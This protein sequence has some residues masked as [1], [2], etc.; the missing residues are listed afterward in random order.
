MIFH[1]TKFQRLCEKPVDPDSNTDSSTIS[2]HSV[3][4]K[5]KYKLP[6]IELKEFDEDL[7]NWR[8]FKNWIRSRHGERQVVVTI[9]LS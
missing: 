8:G 4:L 5:R 9:A 2:G 7:K 1:K 3:K 6:K